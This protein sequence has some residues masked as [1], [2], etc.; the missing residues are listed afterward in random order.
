MDRLASSPRFYRFLEAVPGLITWSLFI[1]PVILAKFRPQLVAYF[2][3]GYSIFWVYS[4]VLFIVY[5]YIGHKKVLFVTKTDWLEKLKEKFPG[6]WEGYYYAALIPFASESIDILRPTIQSVVNANFP[7]NRNI[8]C[9]SS[10][11]ASP[12]GL[13]IAKQLAEEFKDDFVHVWVTEHE[14]VAGEVKGKAANE[15]HGGRFLYDRILEVGLDPAKVLVSSS[16]ADM[17]SHKQYQPYL[18][19]KFLSEGEKKHTRIYQPVPTDYTDIWDANFFSRIIVTIGAQWRMAL[20]QRNDHRFTVYSFYTMSMK[21]LKDIDF[22]DPD[23]IPEDLRTMFNAIFTFGE[24]FKIIPLFIP[25]S[26]RPV[27]GDNL[28]KGFKEQYKQM[29]RWAWGI[30]EFP[31]N[32]TEAIKNKNIPWKVKLM[33]ILNEIR[34]SLEWTTAS[35]L[36]LFGGT[37]PLLLNEDFRKTRLAYAMPSLLALLLQ[38][39][40]VGILMI[41][42]IE[43]KI[44]PRRPKHKS[45]FFKVFSYAQWLLLPYVGF[46]VSTLPALEAQTR[47]IFNKRIVYIESNKEKKPTK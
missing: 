9:L 16:D 4:S 43:W 6:Q 7:K 38:L 29:R 39:A 41:I 46:L 47:L 12:K 27:Q 40:S 14:L 5:A 44:A 33:P 24:D 8:L 10:E 25:V 23:L 30:S 18:L 17:I 1:L 34:S 37:I 2:V 42:Y 11:K 28:W 45:I 19:Y 32:F 26:G 3:L 22:W 13:E 15:N 21:T 31:H 35:V 20:V 36:P